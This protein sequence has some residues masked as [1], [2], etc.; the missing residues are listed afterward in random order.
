M[1]IY[2]P[3]LPSHQRSHTEG[4]EVRAKQGNKSNNP[5]CSL[6]QNTP[7]YTKSL[8]II[9]LH[10]NYVCSKCPMV[11]S[12]PLLLLVLHPSPNPWDLLGDRI[13][14]FFYISLVP[15]TK[16]DVQN[17]KLLNE[18]VIKWKNEARSK[19]KVLCS[20]SCLWTQLY[21]V[22]SKEWVESSSWKSLVLTH[23]YSTRYKRDN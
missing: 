16:L 10:N 22:I 12:K 9:M 1:V 19:G 5:C 7:C 14:I 17:R 18:E 8:I 20:S 2:V 13:C 23:I 4:V 6:V 11:L 21:L 3:L 15:C